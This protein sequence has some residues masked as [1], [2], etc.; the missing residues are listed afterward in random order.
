MQIK[1]VCRSCG[2]V[3][4]V[5]EHANYQEVKDCLRG[6]KPLCWVRAGQDVTLPP[7]RWRAGDRQ[8]S[9]AR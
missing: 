6:M 7:E 3:M 1:H 2:E 5:H 8:M 9:K 4:A